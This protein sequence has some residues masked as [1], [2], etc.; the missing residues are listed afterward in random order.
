ML[1]LL[2]C[3]E[4]LAVPADHYGVLLG[5]SELLAV[6]ADHYGTSVMVF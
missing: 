1:V 6:P 3:S 4:L 2:G 5:C